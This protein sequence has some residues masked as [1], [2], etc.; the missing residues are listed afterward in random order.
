MSTLRIRPA[1]AADAD[2]LTGLLAGLSPDSAYLRF[3]AAIGPVP[4]PATV[5]ALLPDGVRGAALLGFVG[6]A[7]VAHGMWARV[8]H[9]RSAEIALVVA[10][11]HQQQGIGTLLATAVLD[12]LATR[13][14]ERVEVYAGAGNRAVARMLA[15]SSPEAERERDGATVTYS[16][17][18]AQR[19][20]RPT[21]ASSG[22]RRPSAA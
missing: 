17:R 2:A 3:Q 12:D 8:G 9:S 19:R 16:F 7:L 1:S 21:R 22:P 10:D 5:R 15:R 4:S 18:V 6:D 13:G 11:G 20:G 14:I